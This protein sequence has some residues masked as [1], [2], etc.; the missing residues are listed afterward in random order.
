MRASKGDNNEISQCP[1]CKKGFT[2]TSVNIALLSFLTAPTQPPVQKRQKLIKA[3]PRGTCDECEDDAKNPADVYCDECKFNLCN[4]CN[5]FIHG[6]PKRKNH[7]V[8]PWSA[9]IDNSCIKCLVHPNHDLELVCVKC[10]M[11]MVCVLCCSF[12]GL[13][14]THDV[15]P[16][17]TA[18]EICRAKIRDLNL[19]FNPALDIEN[20]ETQIKALEKKKNELLQKY[21][22]NL[23]ECIEKAKKI[24]AESIAAVEQEFNTATSVLYTKQ[25]T[26]NEIALAK[27]KLTTLCGE[28]FSAS[29]NA[30]KYVGPHLKDLMCK[31]KD[32]VN[33]ADAVKMKINMPDESLF[34]TTTTT[35]TRNMPGK[36]LLTGLGTVKGSL[37]YVVNLFDFAT[38]SV[39]DIQPSPY[40]IDDEIHHH[41]RKWHA[42]TTLP[43]GK[44]FICGGVHQETNLDTCGIIDIYGKYSPILSIMHTPRTHAACVMYCQDRVLITGGNFQLH[45]LYSCEGFDITTNTINPLEITMRCDRS[46]HTASL[47]PSGD[48]YICGGGRAHEKSAEILYVTDDRLSHG[49]EPYTVLDRR[50]H[51]A[52]VL[53]DGRVF[54]AGGSPFNST[55]FYDYRMN[56]NTIG[57]ILPRSLWYH[58]AALGPD[59]RVY[60]FGGDRDPGLFSI[61]DP[62]ANKCHATGIKNLNLASCN[63]AL[64]Y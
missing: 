62:V 39:T 53:N 37:K 30:K 41:L 63:A 52:T 27:E 11:E 12:S 29:G 18:I 22:A 45:K 32:V 2:D 7:I 42:S 19:K 26:T 55:E 48:I 20:I 8:V 21:Q 59:G 36:V 56:K 16:V 38:M 13:H 43:N 34:Q 9:E 60:L 24:H 64:I 3:A 33:I 5:K 50:G 54:I 15:V 47:L 40:D 14:S 44:V 1:F 49:G 35:T 17:E 23:D 58:G 6:T 10:D 31:I 28:V 4:E 57:P 46:G 61:Y 25:N 51:T